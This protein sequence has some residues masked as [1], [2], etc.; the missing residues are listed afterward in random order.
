MGKSK[1]FQNCD[2]LGNI[3]Q[4]I[5]SLLPKNCELGR[6]GSSQFVE[7]IEQ[8]ENS[9]SEESESSDEKEPYLEI[10]R[11]KGSSGFL[12]FQ[13]SLCT[14]AALEK[15]MDDIY[16]RDRHFQDIKES[17]RTLKMSDYLSE[18]IV[19]NAYE[20]SRLRYFQVPYKKIIEG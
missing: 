19:G 5:L 2:Q 13:S 14:S 17:L 15:L 6:L 1:G 11:E 8:E 10:P 3:P 4:K 16:L 18:T 12:S 9:H 7:I 20:S